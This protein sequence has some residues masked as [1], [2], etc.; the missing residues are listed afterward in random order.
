MNKEEQIII[1]LI[2]ACVS[3]KA[4]DFIPF[5][6]EKNVK[7]AFPNKMLFYRSLKRLINCAEKDC[8]GNLHPV[9]ERLSGI[10]FKGG[11]RLCFY[12]EGH[13]YALINLEYKIENN[14]VLLDTYPF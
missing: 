14:I 13:K 5:L 12:D 8:I 7:V 10:S 9:E 11:H 3:F 1:G 6:L 4:K 2:H